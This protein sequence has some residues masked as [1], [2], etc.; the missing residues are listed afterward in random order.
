MNKTTQKFQVNAINDNEIMTSIKIS[1]TS[2]NNFLNEHSLQLNV[3][4]TKKI[5][6]F[7]KRQQNQKISIP[8]SQLIIF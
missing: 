8:Q 7:P 1:N 4:K 6:D 2:I 3:K 5:F